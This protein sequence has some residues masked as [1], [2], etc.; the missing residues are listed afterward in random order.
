MMIRPFLLFLFALAFPTGVGAQSGSGSADFVASFTNVMLDFFSDPFGFLISSFINEEEACSNLLGLFDNEVIGTCTCE[1]G[2]A[3]EL[4]VFMKFQMEATCTGDATISASTSV[5]QPFW[6][7]LLG[8]VRVFDPIVYSIE[9]GFPDVLTTPGG[10]IQVDGTAAVFAT[11]PLIT[12]V[13]ASGQ[14]L[15]DVCTFDS[16]QLVCGSFCIV[17]ETMAVCAA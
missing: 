11:P 14:I 10:S 17:P 1:A 2:L 4:L 13:D 16:V 8:G 6:A 12:M 7:A 15:N 3:T 9:V 5:S